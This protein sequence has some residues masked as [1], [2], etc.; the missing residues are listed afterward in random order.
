MDDPVTEEH[1]YDY[2]DPLRD[3]IM[4][5]NSKVINRA[6][7]DQTTV[8]TTANHPVIEEY[9][10]PVSNFINLQ[11]DSEVLERAED[12]QHYYINEEMGGATGVIARSNEAYLSHDD[13]DYYVNEG[14]GGAAEMRIKC[15]EAYGS[16]EQPDSFPDP[17]T[18]T[19][20]NQAYTSVSADTE[21]VRDEET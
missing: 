13:Q 21:I 4:N 7:D 19:I 2:I 10:E 16:M 20:E 3:L 14:M 9:K 1:L 11:S 18:P 5:I 17:S 12:D 8:S 6:E 15:N